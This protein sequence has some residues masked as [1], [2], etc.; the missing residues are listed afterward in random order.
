[1][2]SRTLTQ[3]LSGI[4]IGVEP[5][6]S[7]EISSTGPSSEQF[8]DQQLRWDHTERRLDSQPCR[9]DVAKK[10]SG[11]TLTEKRE[12]AAR[13]GC[14]GHNTIGCTAAIDRATWKP[15]VGERVDQQA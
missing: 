13:R 1:M 3:L 12:Q 7:R 9:R 11:P 2:S 5:R 10:L 6:Q 15:G 4:P 8:T 14:V